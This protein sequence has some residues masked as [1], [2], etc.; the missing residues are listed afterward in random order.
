MNVPNLASHMTSLLIRN[1]H[2]QTTQH[3][4]KDRA[5]PEPWGMDRLTNEEA[6]ADRRRPGATKE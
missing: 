2:E 1:H 3:S 5:D 6:N 4:G